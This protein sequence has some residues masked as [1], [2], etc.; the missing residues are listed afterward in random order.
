MAQTKI[1]HI[2][3]SSNTTLP[4]TPSGRKPTRLGRGLSALMA[5]PVR[6][7]PITGVDE[8]TVALTDQPVRSGSADISA[9]SE[10]PID[11]EKGGRSDNG[12]VYLSVDVIATNP[13]QPRQAF[14]KDA[15]NH[16]AGSIRSD[17]LMQPIIVRP[18]NPPHPSSQLGHADQSDRSSYELVAGERRLRAAKLAGLNTIPAIVRKLDDRQTA[19]WALIENL[20]R[21]DLNPMERAQAFQHLADQFRLNHEEIAHRVGTERSTVSNYLRLLSLCE[22]AQQ[23]IRDGL[24]S[25]GQAKALAG[26]TNPQQQQIMAQRVVAQGWSVRQVE[27]ELRRMADS[28]DGATKSDTTR[29]S[30]GSP[31]L[32][33][34]EQQLGE[35]LKTKVKIRPGRKKGAGTVSIEFYDLDQFD[36]LLQRMNVS[37]RMD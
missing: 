29:S 26:I 21:E 31:H 36:G 19:E 6:T 10:K 11:S 13:H 15:L 20:Q 22:Y 18:V 25:T 7:S 8:A 14:D 33:D 1:P 28:V 5:Q 3:K 32:R 35:A 30:K 37:M 16:L 34:L 9:S 27:S 12:L 4:P 23:L 24:L 17:G 2:K